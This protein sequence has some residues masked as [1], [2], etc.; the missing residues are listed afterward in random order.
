MGERDTALAVLDEVEAHFTGTPLAAKA[1]VTRE[2][3]IRWKM[4]KIVRRSRPNEPP[5]PTAS[6]SSSPTGGMP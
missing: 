5:P 3:V 4:R 2:E 6:P 1:S